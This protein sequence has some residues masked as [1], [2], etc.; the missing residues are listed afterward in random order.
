MRLLPGA[1]LYRN[2]D[3]KEFEVQ[4][5]TRGTDWE[6]YSAYDLLATDG[7]GEVAATTDQ[8]LHLGD[9]ARRKFRIDKS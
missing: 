1:K 6:G 3:D 9:H 8:Q 2:S 5:P 7:S 4:S